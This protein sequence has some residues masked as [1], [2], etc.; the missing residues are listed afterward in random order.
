MVN[1]LKTLIESLESTKKSIDATADLIE[2][3]TFSNEDVIKVL[4]KISERI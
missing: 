3:G 4:R 1:D 2:N